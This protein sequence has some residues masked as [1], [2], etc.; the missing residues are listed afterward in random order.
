[1][2]SHIFDRFPTAEYDYAQVMTDD[3]DDAEFREWDRRACELDEIA[4]AAAERGDL[5]AAG[6]A[7]VELADHMFQV[8]P[9]D[10]VIDEYLAAREAYQQVD[11]VMATRCMLTIGFIAESV[12]DY[13]TAQQAF[14]IS[15]DEWDEHGERRLHAEA[16]NNVGGIATHTGDYEIA[17][18]AL[19]MAI[20]EYED[21]GLPDEALGPRINLANLYRRAGRRE[22]AESEFRAVRSALPATSRVSILCTASLGALNVES[23]RFSEAVSELT[24]AVEGFTAIG[25]IDDVR[26][27]TMALAFARAMS[28]DL[29]S[30]IST[31][32]QVR[33]EFS[34]IGRPDKAA[35]CDYNLA[36]FYFS[37]NDFV[38]SDLA[39]EHAADG[40]AQAG[41]H[42]QIP[43][44]SWNRVK[45]L[46]TEAG[47]NPARQDEL[48]A[49]ALDTAVSSVI[50]IDY[51]RFQFADSRRR[52]EWTATFADRLATAFDMAHKFGRPDL[53]ADLIE[54]GINAG[55]HNGHAD[56]SMNSLAPFDN[57]ESGSPRFETPDDDESAETLSAAARLLSTAALPMNPPPA[58]IAA[59]NTLLLG[60]QRELAG[61][62]DPLL[63]DVLAA[64]P[65][66]RL[67]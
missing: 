41:M 36:I 1:M 63:A 50:A 27:T 26:D 30:G 39:F 66:V 67:W 53:V 23:C 52:A 48:V 42:H 18:Q 11:T 44:L 46:L 47:M 7:H 56:D 40:L 16:S 31:L 29:A 20:A 61:R 6:A 3:D 32:L 13:H 54:S 12:G 45:R 55:V 38:A 62:L 21:L 37:Q 64:S 5:A 43:N 8:A 14:T 19:L 51:Q 59:S 60:P 2:R 28:G 22:M 49:E 25:A 58:L 24:D 57:S 33:Q 4:T 10:D 9:Y 34:D 65:E 17:E 35:V 15:C